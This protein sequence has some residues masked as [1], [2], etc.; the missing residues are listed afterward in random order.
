MAAN[1]R[2]QG[3][4]QAGWGGQELVVLLSYSLDKHLSSTYNVPD[5]MLG[6]GVRL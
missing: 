3:R 5:T 4:V 1:W 6:T 2:S